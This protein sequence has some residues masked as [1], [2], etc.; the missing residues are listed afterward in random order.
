ML[1]TQ[2][3]MILTNKGAWKNKDEDMLKAKGKNFLVVI[4]GI[5]TGEAGGELSTGPR[6]REFP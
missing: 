4:L 3:I 6:Y 1:H 2:N 5:Y